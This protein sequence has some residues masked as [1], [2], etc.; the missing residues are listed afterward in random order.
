MML[1]ASTG[2]DEIAFAQPVTA[3]RILPRNPVEE[4]VC[5]YGCSETNNFL[6]DLELF[7]VES[8]IGSE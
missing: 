4:R 8:L 1:H 2:A 6:N 7:Y 5:E 3:E